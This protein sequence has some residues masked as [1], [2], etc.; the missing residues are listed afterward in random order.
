[1]IETTVRL[2]R[3][4][5]ARIALACEGRGVTRS[6]LVSALVRYASGKMRP[7]PEGWVRVKYQ[8]RR[9]K[10]EWRCQH[11]VLRPDEYEFFGDMRK[12]MRLS[13]SCI[14]A[15]AVEHYLDEMLAISGEDTDNYRYRNY[16]IARFMAGDVVCWAHCW[17][18]PP[19]IAPDTPTLPPPGIG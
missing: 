7:L 13:V 2:G 5:V 10:E 19:E 11:L 14:V 15:Y 9:M 8:G 16:I 6:C 1:M 18:I 4:T 12:V 17:G 3:E